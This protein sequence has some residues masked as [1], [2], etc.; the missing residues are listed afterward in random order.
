[1]ENCPILIRK[2]EGLE[3]TS[4]CGLCKEYRPA[5]SLKAAGNQWLSKQAGPETQKPLEHQGRFSLAK[6]IASERTFMRS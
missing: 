6:P 1:M 3:R 4:L 2:S 5:V